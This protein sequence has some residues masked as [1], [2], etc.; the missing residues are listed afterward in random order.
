MVRQDWAGAEGRYG[1][2]IGQYRTRHRTV[3]DTAYW[4]GIGR[5]WTRHRTEA[6]GTLARATGGERS[7][8]VLA[9]RSIAKVSTGQRVASA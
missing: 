8:G 1:H 5:Y 7:E 4:H 6:G 3:P 9:G 2:G